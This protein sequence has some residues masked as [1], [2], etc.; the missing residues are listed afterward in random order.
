M[1]GLLLAMFDL[2]S[3]HYH[4]AKTNIHPDD[5]ALLHR[6]PITHHS[7]VARVPRGTHQLALQYDNQASMSRIFPEKL[8]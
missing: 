2:W 6:R 7:I 8:T 3:N 4:Q 5:L 1:V